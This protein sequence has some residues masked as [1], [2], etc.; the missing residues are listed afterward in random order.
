MS[1]ATSG[2]TVVQCRDLRKIF[3]QGKVEVPVLMGVTMEVNEGERVAIVG[4]YGSGKSTMLHLI[5]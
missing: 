4:A 5:G 3:Y 1:S 2:G